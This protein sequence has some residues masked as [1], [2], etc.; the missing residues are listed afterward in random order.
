[1]GLF[2]QQLVRGEKQ[3]ANYNK[4]K[5]IKDIYQIFESLSKQTNL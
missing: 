2:L 4:F 3:I 5:K 1:M